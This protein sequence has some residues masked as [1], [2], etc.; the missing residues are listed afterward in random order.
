MPLAT[1][2]NPDD[3]IFDFEHMMAHR[4][5]FAIMAPLNRFS[6]LPYLL[7]PSRGTDIR[8]GPWHLNHQ[9]SHNDFNGSLPPYWT[10]QSIG[11]GIPANQI[12]VDSS[13]AEAESRTWWTFNNH[14]QH[15]IAN[16]A[17]FPLPTT[18]IPASPSAP[19]W[20]TGVTFPFW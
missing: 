9:Q 8:A 3:P 12:L 2:I 16:N 17:I 4:N 1:L 5:Y 11:F 15:L 10:A 20:W 6:I 7:D 14:Q 13:L 18:E 19:G